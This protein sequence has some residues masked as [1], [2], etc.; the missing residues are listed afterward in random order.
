[1]LFTVIAA[2]PLSAEL[3]ASWLVYELNFELLNASVV[4]IEFHVFLILDYFFYFDFDFSEILLLPRFHF[5]QL[6][7]LCPALS[8]P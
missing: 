6:A 7:L 3:L 2:P 4:C 8:P 1:L 5:Y